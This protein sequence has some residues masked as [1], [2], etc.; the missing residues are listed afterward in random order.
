MLHKVA[1]SLAIFIV[2]TEDVWHCCTFVEWTGSFPGSH[3]YG[4][5][6]NIVDFVIALA[7]VSMAFCVGAERYIAVL[8]CV[9]QTSLLS[10]VQD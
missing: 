10:I 3:S 2:D 7:A 9:S 1:G 4:N 5:S 8:A 6:V